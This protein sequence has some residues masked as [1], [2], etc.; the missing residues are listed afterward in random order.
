MRLDR[1]EPECVDRSVREPRDRLRERRPVGIDRVRTGVGLR[2]GKS[3]V[4]ERPVRTRVRRADA[5]P[6]RDPSPQQ[7]WPDR[8]H[9][10]EADGCLGR[11]AQP[12]DLRRS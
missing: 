5:E 2:R 9:D 12:R 4:L 11:V 3:V 8:C 1:P 7:P 6:D 10:P